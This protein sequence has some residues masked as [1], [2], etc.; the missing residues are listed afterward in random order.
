MT[1]GMGFLA[2]RI[3]GDSSKREAATGLILILV[4]CTALYWIGSGQ[5]QMQAD[6][7]L[8]P[9]LE[10]VRFTRDVIDPFDPRTEE[11]I[12]VG[13][14]KDTRGNDP[15][16]YRVQKGP[17]VFKMMMKADEENKPL[18]VN[19]GQLEFARG[20]RQDIMEIIDDERY[21]EEVAVFKAMEPTATRWIFRYKPGSYTPGAD[22]QS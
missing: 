3:G 5:R 19:L 13:F 14:H 15:A 22:P 6:I 18:Y 11:V 4:S 12:T 17:E 8:D 2:K 10:S 21:F 7:P 9:S 1:I 20:H 16:L